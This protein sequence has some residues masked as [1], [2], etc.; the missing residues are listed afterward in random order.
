MKFVPFASLVAS[1]LF[2]GCSTLN[3]TSKR[4]ME[5][6]VYKVSNQD[7][8]LFYAVIDDDEIKL[9]ALS[10]AGKNR[11]ADTSNYFSIDLRDGKTEARKPIHFR[12]NK[13]D[14]DILSIVFK[15]RPP[16][17][18][19]PQQLLTNFN[20]AGYVGYGSSHYKL[21]F[22]RTPLHTY[23]PRT[24]DFSYSVGLFAGIGAPEI[25]PSVT[26]S[27]IEDEYFGLVIT[28]GVTGLVSVGKFRFGLAFGFDHLMDK[29]RKL[30]IYQGKPWAGLT[31]GLSLN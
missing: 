10:G 16:T 14:L 27:N 9:Y 22:E 3:E 25:T 7:Q 26:N 4:K 31:V 19:F 1:V 17:Q 24:H 20:A 30:W 18:G 29:N 2:F 11:T 23:N 15:Y 21:S 28:K 5:T 13:L 6:G 12:Q 8:K